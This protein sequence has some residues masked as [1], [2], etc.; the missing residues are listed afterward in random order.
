MNKYMNLMTCGRNLICKNTKFMI[1]QMKI[2]YK[3]PLTSRLTFTLNS[4]M[5]RE[6]NTK[7]YNTWVLT[8]KSK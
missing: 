8:C 2:S 3:I 1:N 6:L 5:C 7:I 4:D